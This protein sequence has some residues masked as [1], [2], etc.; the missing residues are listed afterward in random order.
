M[1]FRSR[2]PTTPF[3]PDAVLMF[4][5]L[6]VIG[7]VSL[8]A[9]AVT[10]WV[11]AGPNPHACTVNAPTAPTPCNCEY[12]TF[13]NDFVLSTTPATIGFVANPVVA[14]YC[15]RDFGE[16]Y[17]NEENELICIWNIT[18][19]RSAITNGHRTWTGA[20]DC[21]DNGLDE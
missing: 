20:E 14:F 2:N 10:C 1:T 18:C 7:G 5:C 21:Y 11:N 4:F 6:A 17:K 12:S 15:T 3:V 9:S 8:V 19:R 13:T 16:R